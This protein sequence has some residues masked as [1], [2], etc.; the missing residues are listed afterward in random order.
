M[1]II[2]P[3]QKNEPEAVIINRVLTKT[4]EFNSQFL[5][6]GSTISVLKKAANI[7]RQEVLQDSHRGW[8]FRGNFVGFH[9]NQVAG[10]RNE[11][12]DKTVDVAC[13]LLVQNTGS[14]RQVKHHKRKT[15]NL[16][17]QYIHHF[18]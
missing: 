8:S 4:M 15:T 1:Q 6:D 11:E 10:M 17:T 7:F 9:I 5:D 14:D 2:K 3:L 12:I 13:Q 16:G 18:L